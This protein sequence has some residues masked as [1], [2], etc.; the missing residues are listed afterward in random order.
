MICIQIGSHFRN[1]VPPGSFVR[2]PYVSNGHLSV[3]LF[4][5]LE[6]LKQIPE[7]TERDIGGLQKKLDKL[8]A[9]K[10]KEEEKLKEVMDSLK[11]E[12]QVT[13]LRSPGFYFFVFVF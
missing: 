1:S 8:E 3:F 7:K 6:E 2:Q 9:E 13:F 12:T 10:A 4:Y 11:T 5:Q